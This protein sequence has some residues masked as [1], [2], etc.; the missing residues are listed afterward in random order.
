[1]VKVKNKI[2]KKGKKTR[3]AIPWTAADE[4]RLIANVRNNTENLKKAFK[5]TSLELQRTPAAISSHWYTSTSIKTNHVL[6]FKMSGERI[7][8]NRSRGKGKQTQIPLY[9]KILAL[10]GL[11]Y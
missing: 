11:C 1:M 4:D 10:L 2:P 5:Q 3:K 7:L 9:K 6:F 8:I